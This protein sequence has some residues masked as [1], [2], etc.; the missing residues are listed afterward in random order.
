MKRG[1]EAGGIDSSGSET[2]H[3]AT[4]QSVSN[5]YRPRDAVVSADLAAGY[6]TP[7]PHHA[8]QRV[9][10]SASPGGFDGPREHAPLPPLVGVRGDVL[11]QS[12]DELGGE[13]ERDAEV[14]RD[15]VRL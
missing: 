6:A 11:V 5:P 9:W 12:V 2:S 10:S 1:A 4:L 8:R 14:L 3:V 15:R 7:E 13:V